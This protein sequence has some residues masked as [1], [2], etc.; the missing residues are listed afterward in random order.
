MKTIN[1]KD[2]TKRKHQASLT[3]QK[4]LKSALL[5]KHIFLWQ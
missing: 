3:E 5:A 2:V 4:E 1:S